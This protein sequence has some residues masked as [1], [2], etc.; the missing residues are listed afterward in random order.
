[1]IL[2]KRDEE[3]FIKLRD[4]G[5]MTTRLVGLMHF[6]GVA[7]TTVLRRLRKLEDASY[8]QRIT[9]L[10][11]FEVAWAVTE[12]VAA[13]VGEKAFKRHFRRDTLDHD[14]KLT[15]LRL[16]LEGNGFAWSWIPEHEIRSQL[17]RRHGLRNLKDRVIPDGLMGIKTGA[18][19]ES[20]AIELELN[21]KNQKRYQRILSDYSTKR[22]V[23][24]VWYVVTNRTLG[25]HLEQ[26]WRKCRY[27]STETKFLWSIFDELIAD[28]ASAAVYGLGAQLRLCDLLVKKSGV[29]EKE[30][31]KPLAQ[32][33]AQAVSNLKEIKIL[34]EGDLTPQNLDGKTLLAS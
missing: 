2:T 15:S 34:R 14:L 8:V 21:F 4:F 7:L 28:P 10:E 19:S 27:T 24:A 13:V 11:N 31:A 32:T 26:L 23:W 25:R 16:A 20:V 33:P 29:A 3:L 6:P 30:N 17:A 5:L 1:M 12:K 18:A 22:S 9:G